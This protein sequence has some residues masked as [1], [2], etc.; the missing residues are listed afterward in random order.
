[1]TKVAVIT[2]AN[3]GVGY[4]LTIL[5]AKNCYKVYATMRNLSNGKELSE[6]VEKEGLSKLVSLV[7]LD[8]SSDDSVKQCFE[9][10]LKHDT[11]DVLAAN[12]GYSQVGCVE[13]LTIK[14]SKDQFE[15][16]YFGVIRCLH[17]VLPT[18]R[19]QKSGRILVVSS[20]GGLNGVPFN[21]IYC[22]SKFAVEGLVESCAPVYKEFG[23]HIS[24][25]EPGAILTSFVKNVKKSESDKKIDDDLLEKRDIVNKKMM[26]QFNNSLAQ[27]PMQVAE[28]M[29]KALTDENPHMRYLT[30]EK[31]LDAVKSKY[32]DPTGDVHLKNVKKRFFE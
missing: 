32:V 19:K 14:D 27:T 18:M 6:Q 11:I 17:G 7:Q 29:L 3:S 30:N 8:V 28:V 20:V 26:A 25:I 16:N 5:L 2:G 10:I 24:L 1:M 21:D 22:S 31:Y 9:S 15:T 4:A 12:A 13:E 23:I